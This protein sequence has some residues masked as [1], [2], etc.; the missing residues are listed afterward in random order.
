MRSS[1][2]YSLSGCLKTGN[3]TDSEGFFRC[4][5]H[6]DAGILEVFQG[7]RAQH[8]GKRTADRGR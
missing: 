7:K 2:R 4:A 1:R 6:F 8:I 3:V 5:S